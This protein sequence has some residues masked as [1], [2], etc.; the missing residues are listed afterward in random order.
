[1]REGEEGEEEGEEEEGE[2]GE[3]KNLQKIDKIAH[4]SFAG[5]LQ[6]TIRI[7]ILKAQTSV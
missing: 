6:N 2:E 5:K 3:G 4:F 7:C 1:M